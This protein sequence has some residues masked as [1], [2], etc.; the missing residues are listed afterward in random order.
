MRVR[1]DSKPLF[2]SSTVAHSTSYLEVHDPANTCQ[3]KR[4]WMTFV[5]KPA[6]ALPHDCISGFF[7]RQIKANRDLLETLNLDDVCCTVA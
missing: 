6:I 5:L 3:A 4:V 2:F 7:D 1:L